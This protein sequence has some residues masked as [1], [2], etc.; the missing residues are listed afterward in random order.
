MTARPPF[1]PNERFLPMITNPDTVTH[2]FQTFLGIPPTKNDPPACGAT[3]TDAYDFPGTARPPCPECVELVAH[4][5]QS[6]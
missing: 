3:L 1:L 5:R 2:A 4:A 6:R